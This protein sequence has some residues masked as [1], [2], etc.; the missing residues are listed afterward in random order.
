[1]VECGFC[2]CLTNLFRFIISYS[3]TFPALP[4]W[5]SDLI[6]PWLECLGVVVTSGSQSCGWWSSLLFYPILQLF[7]VLSKGLCGWRAAWWWALRWT[8]LVR[9]HHSFHSIALVTST[10]TPSL[11]PIISHAFAMYSLSLC[12]LS[13]EYQIA[14]HWNTSDI[15]SSTSIMVHHST[16]SPSN[17]WVCTGVR[18]AAHTQ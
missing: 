7:L 11:I 6:L 4:F 1:M 9:A 14:R 15:S 2:V 16:T 3:C 10:A 5:H 17:V 13:F 8:A 18:L 12:F